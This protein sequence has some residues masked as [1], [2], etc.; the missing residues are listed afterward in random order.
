M[1]QKMMLYFRM[2]SVGGASVSPRTRSGCQLLFQGSSIRL[3]FNV[4]KKSRMMHQRER[5]LFLPEERYL[6][7]LMA[8]CVVAYHYMLILW[9]SISSLSCADFIAVPPGLT[10][11]SMATLITW[12]WRASHS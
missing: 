4:L 12:R 11:C 7:Y 3:Y 10:P 5:E 9:F 6:E 8:Q 2:C 1:K